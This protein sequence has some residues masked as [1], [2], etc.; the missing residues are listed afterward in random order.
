MPARSIRAAHN[1]STLQKLNGWLAAES[2]KLQ[3]RLL[4]DLVALLWIAGFAWQ[5][6]GFLLRDDLYLYGD[7]PGQFYRLWQLLT[8]TWPEDGWFI[9]WSPYWFAGWSELQFYPPGFAMLGWLIWMAS[10]QQ[11]SPVFVYQVVVFTTFAGPAVAFYLLLAWALNDRLAGLASAWLTMVTPYPLGGA[12]GAIVGLVGDR[13][14]FGLTPLLILAGV[15]GMQ[16]GRRRWAGPAAGLVLAGILLSHPYQAILPI[17]ILGLYTLSLGEGWQA[18]LGWLA[19]VVLLGF[20]LTAFWWLPLGLRQRFFVSIVEAPLLE[21]RAI[22]QNMWVSE[23]GWLLAAAVAGSLSRAGRRRWLPLAIL[24]AGVF[25]LGFIFFNYLVLVERFHFYALVPNRFVTGVT[26]SLFIGLALGFSEL[27]W[28][29]ARLLQRWNWGVLGL[30]LVLVVAW[31]IYSQAAGY[32]DFSRWMRKWQ[33]AADR[34]PLFLSEAGARYNLGPVWETMA[35][36]PGRILFTSHYGLL[37]DVPTTL[38]A[39]TPV[40]TGRQIIGGTFTTRNPV[41]SYLWSGQAQPEVLRGKVEAHD[42]KSLA[43]VPWEQMTDE[44]L[45][46]LVRH[47]NVTLIVTTVT[48]ERARA[49]LDASA[50]FRPAWSNGLFT[51]Y[52]PLDYEPAWVEADRAGAAASR[53]DRKAIDIDIDGA[54]PGATLLVKVAHYDL[55]RAEANGRPLPIEMDE[56]GLMKI[57]LPPGSYILHLRCAPRWPEWLGGGLSLAAL[58]GLFLFGWT[59]SRTKTSTG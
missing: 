48:D 7:H 32:Y 30:P 13:L 40:L 23:M 34:T 10:F 38:K 53:F 59:F 56:Y 36:T 41:A 12:W 4:I 18:R 25:T 29:G 20:G 15:W 57:P 50:R 45:F 35:A 24:L 43:G 51:F 21:V 14:A 44:F 54:A 52:S 5:N 11:L 49:F 39:A 19:W 3:V 46:N 16:A 58:A 55:W 31:F 42:D 6:A 33:P 17:G 8:I 1:G 22:F 28:L 26:F 2:S 37:F 9:G 27:A 47:Y